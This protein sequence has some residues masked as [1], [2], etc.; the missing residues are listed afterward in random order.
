MRRAADGGPIIGDRSPRNS[1]REPVFPPTVRRL[2]VILLTLTLTIALA[3]TA[4]AAAPK[5]AWGA[6]VL[7]NGHPAGPIYKALGVDDVQ[8]AL[9]W[10]TVAPTQPASERN[11]ADP[12]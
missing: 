1:L 11:P 10:D 2:S 6:V 8:F 9:S 7:P 12:A 4:S 5:A 3:G